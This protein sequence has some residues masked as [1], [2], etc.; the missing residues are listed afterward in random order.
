MRHNFRKWVV[1]GILVL[2]IG[3][4][5]FLIRS[6]KAEK[7]Q[8][9]QSIQLLITDDGWGNPT[10]KQVDIPAYLPNSGITPTL[11]IHFTITGVNT[12]ETTAF[13][14][15]DPWEDWKN[16]SIQGGI[17][18]PV[19]D[20][21]L[22][23]SGTQGDW[24]CSLTPTLTYN[25]ESITLGINWPGNGSANNNVQLING[26]YVT[27][28]VDSFP[29]G[30][31]YNLTITVRDLDQEA[32]KYTDVYLIWEENDVEFNHTMG[33]NTVGN[34]RNGEYTFYISKEDQGENIPK[35]ITIAVTDASSQ[36]SGYT[37]VFMNTP[38]PLPDLEIRR[39]QGG[40]GLK[41]QIK[42]NGTVDATN[43]S[44]N[45]T[46]TGAWMIVP[47]LEQY[48]TTFDLGSGESK[49]VTVLVFGLGK[50]TITINAKCSEGTS[51]EKTA[52]GTIFLFFILG[53]K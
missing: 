45:I 3:T 39:L 15:D 26:S 23:H 36:L 25:H 48:Q 2:F 47:P 30:Q 46:F 40:F 13:Y 1:I 42:N 21:S 11:S 17:L 51:V 38:T 35:N 53:V 12:S 19:N 34:G 4:N 8:S 14:G 43:V 18:Y 33:E 29:W 49:D 27:P 32:L 41:V 16:I 31:G 37:K 22:Y 24:I 5:I 52:T 50:T 44:L 20:S 10:D 9:S 6:T 7:N 28:R